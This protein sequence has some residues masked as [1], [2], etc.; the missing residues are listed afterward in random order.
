MT[1]EPPSPNR[2]GGGLVRLP[3]VE[4]LSRGRRKVVTVRDTSS[5][6]SAKPKVSQNGSSQPPDPEVLERPL[7]R[8]FTAEYKL[9]ILKE[10]DNLSSSELG[11][12]LRREGLY[13][14]ALTRWRQ[15]RQ[16]GQLA[17]LEPRKRGRKAQR[18]ADHPWANK[19]AQLEREVANLERRLEQAHRI[20]DVQKKLSELLGLSE[21]SRPG[22]GK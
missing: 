20:I 1:A 14:S 15:E 5:E 9:R 10:T 13:R 6:H 19:V 8:T 12:V 18:V 16:A 11:A 17:S 3:T 2:G 21:S 4:E 7:R 22:E